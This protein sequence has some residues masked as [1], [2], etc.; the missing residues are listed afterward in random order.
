MWFIHSLF[1]IQAS[2]WRALVVL[3]RISDTCP[4][5]NVLF[6]ENIVKLLTVDV[7]IFCPNWQIN[8]C[9]YFVT[10]HFSLEN[11]LDVCS[12][13][14]N[15]FQDPFTL[16]SPMSISITNEKSDNFVIF[17]RNMFRMVELELL[18]LPSPSTWGLIIIMWNIKL[19]DHWILWT[20]SK[21]C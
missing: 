10:K 7:D 4:L 19:N 3:F 12:G 15:W 21:Q 6:V 5:S 16:V 18:T 11:K 17:I 8:G 1:K 2:F 14:S 20:R 13:L 9:K